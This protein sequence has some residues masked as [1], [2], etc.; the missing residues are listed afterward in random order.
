MINSFRVNID[1]SDF[2]HT[3]YY[4][5]SEVDLTQGK[6]KYVKKNYEASVAT[7][8]REEKILET[9]AS[10]LDSQN[11]EEWVEKTLDRISLHV[12]YK[13]DNFGIETKEIATTY[14][15]NLIKEDYSTLEY[16]DELNEGGRSASK[17]SYLRH[18]S[19]S[20]RLNF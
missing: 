6:I 13:E 20:N 10:A 3:T 16:K 4:K 15:L 19:K 18:L 14:D 9:L 12:N 7:L 11:H 1:T 8:E 5:E 2:N 17:Y